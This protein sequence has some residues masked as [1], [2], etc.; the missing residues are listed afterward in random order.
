MN[1]DKMKIITN[2]EIKSQFLLNALFIGLDY[3]FR[4]YV[5]VHFDGL[6]NDFLVHYS[7]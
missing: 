7:N 5:M 3:E 4:V 6:K 2:R 1:K